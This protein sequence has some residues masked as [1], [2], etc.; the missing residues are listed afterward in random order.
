VQANELFNN[1][2]LLIQGALI[3]ILVNVIVYF[4]SFIPNIEDKI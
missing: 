4:C 2:G 1:L 3:Y